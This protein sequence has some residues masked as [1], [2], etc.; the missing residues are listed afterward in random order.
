VVLG[1]IL[2]FSMD[3]ILDP[4]KNILPPVRHKKN[5]ANIIMCSKSHAAPFSLFFDRSVSAPIRMVLQSL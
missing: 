4:A 2:N 1:I 3:T 5:Y